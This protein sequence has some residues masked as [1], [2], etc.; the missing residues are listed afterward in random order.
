M[1]SFHYKYLQFLKVSI[2]GR[3]FNAIALYARSNDTL[4]DNESD[5]TLVILNFIHGCVLI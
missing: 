3:H 5:F 2:D 4:R 1:T